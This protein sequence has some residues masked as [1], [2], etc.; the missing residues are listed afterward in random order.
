MQSDLGGALP[1]EEAGHGNQNGKTWDKRSKDCIEGSN[2][3]RLA[4]WN[5][6]STSKSPY[7]EA[8]IW[9]KQTWEVEPPNHR[10]INKAQRF[11]KW[12]DSYPNNDI[13]R[14][15]SSYPDAENPH[16]NRPLDIVW[17]TQPLPKNNNKGSIYK[18]IMT[19]IAR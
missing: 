2:G 7:T 14:I 17:E 10:N 5:E 13:D 9:E 8:S 19:S 11:S 1:V 6:E 18:D 16:A 3:T 12:M 15:G 4:R